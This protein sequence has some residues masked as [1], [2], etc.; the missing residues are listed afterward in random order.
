MVIKNTFLKVG[1][2]L[3]IIIISI[4]SILVTNTLTSS[5]EENHLLTRVYFNA[6]K[7]VYTLVNYETKLN[8]TDSSIY[9][10]K[11]CRYQTETFCREGELKYQSFCLYK[12]DGF[13]E[14]GAGIILLSILGLL[15]LFS[16]SYYIYSKIKVPIQA[17][18]DIVHWDEARKLINLWLCKEYHIYYWFDNIE[19]NFRKNAI[20]WFSKQQD[21]SKNGEKFMRA[22]VEL[23]EGDETGVYTIDV[24]LSRGEDWIKNGN[25]FKE[26]VSFDLADLKSQ[27]MPRNEPK[28]VLSRRLEK[29]S[30][31]SPDAASKFEEQLLQQEVEKLKEPSTLKEEQQPQDLQQEQQG[32]PPWY[33]KRY[34]G[35]RR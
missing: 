21:Y 30:Q 26:R 19:L 23:N 31:L 10:E 7:D 22:Q 33:Q 3:S 6:T 20:K 17:K 25:F 27:Q 16:F 4:V 32:Q 11:Y 29:L 8:L 12:P 34:K 24:N 9:N 2:I 18:E 14:T 1:I 35:R 15:L 13:F 5:C 28:D